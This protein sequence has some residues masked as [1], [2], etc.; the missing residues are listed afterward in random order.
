[1]LFAADYPFLDV[2]WTIIIFF[3]WVVYI[4]MIILILSDVFRRHD[5]GGGTK[6]LWTV[7]L[8]IF[9]FITALVYLIKQGDAMAQRR[10]SDAQAAQSQFDDY[11]KNVAGSGGG[12]AGEI[13]KA[14]E[15]LDAGTITQ[16][17]FDAIKAKALA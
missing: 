2:L 3:A 16:Q 17:E 7:F 12:A 11:V 10:A 15:L 9:P 14:K 13:A 6:A 5:I 4:W 8:I 1:M